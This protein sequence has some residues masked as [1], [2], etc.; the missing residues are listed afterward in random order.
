MEAASSNIEPSLRRDNPPRLLGERD[1]LYS[2]RG[3]EKPGLRYA[4]NRFLEICDRPDYDN[5]K[6]DH[7]RETM[8]ALFTAMFSLSDVSALSVTVRRAPNRCLYCDRP[9]GR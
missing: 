9:G 1:R 8:L 3:A 5:S 7:E 2:G 6:S 4:G